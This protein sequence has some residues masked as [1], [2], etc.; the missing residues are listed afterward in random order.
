M[1]KLT[2]T[3][4]AIETDLL[5]K[6]DKW[7]TAHGYTNRSKAVRDI[8]RNALVAEEWARPGAEVIAT[9]SIIYDHGART[10]SKKLAGIQHEDHHAVL[11]SQHVHLDAERCLE[12]ILLRGSARRLRR[13]TDAIIATRGVVAG[14]LTIMSPDV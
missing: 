1:S 5:E 10:L 11:C 8:I 2:R 14:K 9:V 12:V 3:A 6:F 13:L 7:M 4:L